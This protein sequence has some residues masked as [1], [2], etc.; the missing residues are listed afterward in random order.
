MFDWRAAI[1]IQRSLWLYSTCWSCCQFHQHFT[2]A[3]FIQK[4]FWQLFSSYV[5]RKKLPKRLSHKKGRHKMLMKIDT[6][7]QFHQRFTHVFFI[8]KCFMQLPLVTFQLCNFWHQN[9]GIK[10]ERT[11]KMLMKLT[12]N[13]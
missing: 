1:S 9:I 11:S 10:F 6:L 12:P 13:V 5:S 3:F 2:C 7:G 4:S 8:Q